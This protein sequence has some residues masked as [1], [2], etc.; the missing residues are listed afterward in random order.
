MRPELSGRPADAAP[1]FE[2]AA[3]ASASSSRPTSRWAGRRALRRVPGLRVAHAL[4]PGV[5][6]GLIALG[7]PALRAGWARLTP[8]RSRISSRVLRRR[9]AAAP[10]RHVPRRAPG[11]ERLL[12]TWDDAVANGLFAMNVELDEPRE[13]RRAAFEKAPAEPGPAPPRRTPRARSLVRA[14]PTAPGGCAA[15]EAGSASSSSWPR[16][17]GRG[18]R[19]SRSTPCQIRRT[20]AP[21]SPTR[22]SWPLWTR[23]PRGWLGPASPDLDLAAGRA[24]DAGRRRAVRDDAPWPARRPAMARRPRPSTS[25]ATTAARSLRSPWSPRRAWSRPAR[26]RCPERVAPIEGW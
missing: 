19:G 3:T 2:S 4:A 9:P 7:Q 13:R 6:P 25:T 8:R 17:H 23:R 1:A 22:S 12:A 24:L 10:D 15:S 5:R 20:P 18:S 16:S 26:S 21:P 14:R 11:P